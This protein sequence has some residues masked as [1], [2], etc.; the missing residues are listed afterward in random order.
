MRLAVSIYNLGRNLKVSVIFI[1]GLIKYSDPFRG[2]HRISQPRRAPLQVRA[3]LL[4]LGV[5]EG[6]GVGV[7][8]DSFSE[9]TDNDLN[10]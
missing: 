3:T 10:L 6:N 9:T 5:G 8:K 1:Q 7:I 4:I 2:R